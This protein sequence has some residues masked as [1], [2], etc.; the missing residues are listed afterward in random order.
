[1]DSILLLSGGIDSTTL[2]Y[3]LKSQGIN[4]LCLIFDYGQ[5]LIKEIDYAKRNCIANGVPFQIIKIDMNYA[6]KC[7][8]INTDIP[9]STHR[10]IENINANTPNSYVPF[11]NGI[12]LAYAISIGESRGIVDIYCGGNGLNSGLY[13]DDTIEF[14]NG[15]E[16]VANI[17]TTPD[18]TPRIHFPFAEI[19]KNE[20]VRIGNKL[21]IDYSNTWSCYQN[22][23]SHCMV[24][25]SCIQRI[26]ALSELIDYNRTY[27]INE[28]VYSIQGEGANTGKPYI[29]LRFSGCN[30]KCSFCDTNH[31][32]YTEMT[33]SE[34]LNELMKY[35]T[36]NVSL[37]G[38]EPTLQVDQNLITSLK[39]YGYQLQIETNGTNPVPEGIDYVVVSPKESNLKLF[40]NFRGLSVD[41]LRI[42]IDD[43]ECNYPINAKNTYVSPVFIDNSISE[44]ALK[45]CLEMIRKDPSKRLSVQIH[46]F[47]GIE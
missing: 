44:I 24:C 45:I 11:R 9:I 27:R 21:N 37:C 40:T 2:L 34:I 20:I 23:S 43:K 16:S 14:A 19:S 7:S 15:F 25:D 12:F 47:L 29:F 3:Q 42:L 35:N 46:K 10:T 39:S 31:Q 38:G 36:H 13:W 8:L 22:G 26:Q 30:F 33:L 1:M 17:G 18:Y 41:E 4:P 28:I 5:S 6:D 32:S